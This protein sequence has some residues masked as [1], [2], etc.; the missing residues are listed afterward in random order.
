MATRVQT[1][2]KRP[3]RKRSA[4][5]AL[6]R[7]YKTVSK[8]HL[9]QLF[10][11]DPKRGERMIAEAAGVFLDYS[12]NR[13]TDETLKTLFELA[14]ESGLRSRI[15]AMFRG[16]RINVTENR[17]VLHVALRARKEAS[18]LLS[19][20]NPAYNPFS[21]QNG[22][23]WPHDN[24]IIAMGFRRYGFV[25][26]AA[27]IARDISEAASY[28]VF[29]RLP[30]LYSGICREPGSFP[31]QYLGANVPQAWAAGSVFHLLRAILGLE[32]DAHARTLY[33]DPVLPRWLPEV[34]LHNLR[35]ANSTVTIRFWSED[36]H[37]R[38]EVLSC[39][40]ELHVQHRPPLNNSTPITAGF[41]RAA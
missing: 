27:M 17:A 41:Q 1:I 22:S 37:S 20:D 29:Y 30:E 23:V 15:D 36:N 21:Y 40:G 12:K 16:E 2:S 33:V 3:A 31:V 32:A 4:W 8:L 24:G 13:V 11:D 5:D 6:A 35:V 28:F 19:A 39:D 25:N 18:I 14:V 34:T 26:E 38:F 9:R 7:H 10:A